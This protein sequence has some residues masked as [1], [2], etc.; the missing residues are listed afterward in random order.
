MKFEA[1]I[2]LL[3]G[4]WIG[5]L[6][7]L[8]FIEAPLKFTAPGISVKLGLGIGQIM[9]TVLNRI[10]TLLSAVFLVFVLSRNNMGLYLYLL[11]GLLILIVLMQSFYFLPILNDRVEIILSGKDVPASS[12]HVLFII[13]EINKL[14]T[15]ILLFFKTYKYINYVK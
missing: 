5:L 6:L 4:V 12:H 10:E 3:L 7:G 11:T 14:I 8:S 13:L 1:L 2:I 9:F 15:L